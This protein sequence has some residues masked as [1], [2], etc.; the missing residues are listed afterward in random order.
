MV[1]GASLEN[2]NTGNRI[3]GSNPSLSATF[4]NRTIARPLHDGKNVPTSKWKHSL[5]KAS[6]FGRVVDAEGDAES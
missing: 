2:W 5:L 3:G 1:D 4:S 6:Q